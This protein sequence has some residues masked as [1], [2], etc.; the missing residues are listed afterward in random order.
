MERNPEGFSYPENRYAMPEDIPEHRAYFVDMYARTA[1][2]EDRARIFENAMM[3]DTWMF[4]EYPQRMEKLRYLAE[5]IRTAFDT[6]D[7]PEG[8]RWEEPLG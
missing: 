6:Q 3:G 5:C 4:A 2:I 8:T 1:P 7:W